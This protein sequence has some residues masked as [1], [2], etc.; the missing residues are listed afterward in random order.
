[1]SL[2]QNSNNFPL[3]TAAHEL[4]EPFKANQYQG[5]T[6][7][8]LL[9]LVPGSIPVVISA[10]HAVKHYRNQQPKSEDIRT[11]ALARQLA[12][13]TGAHAIINARTTREDDPNWNQAGLY[14]NKLAE[15]VQTCNAHFV[16]DIHGLSD[17]HGRDVIIGTA[18]GKNLCGKLFLAE[19][20][21]RSFQRHGL[22]SCGID[23]LGYKAASAHTISSYISREY[24]IPTMQLEIARKFR[25]IRE[26]P[27]NYE[28]LLRALVEAVSDMISASK[29][30]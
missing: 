13:L 4:E 22:S 15:L 19:M 16:L 7:N 12:Q 23:E 21:L 11:G 9:L 10:P 5:N 20:L 25:N 18:E 29:T 30:N 24:H 27:A 1:M 14:K 2:L 3:A 28:T 8:P 26:Q 17:D 6:T